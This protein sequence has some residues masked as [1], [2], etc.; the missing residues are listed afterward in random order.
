MTFDPLLKPI[1]T[2]TQQKVAHWY[3][4]DKTYY[5]RSIFDLV[6]FID[7]NGNEPEYFVP[8]VHL[9]FQLHYPQ[10]E[11]LENFEQD[12]EQV[13]SEIKLKYQDFSKNYL[14]ELNSNQ[15]FF[16]LEKF[17]GNVQMDSN[18]DKKRKEIINEVNNFIQYPL[19]LFIHH[20]RAC[21]DLQERGIGACVF[22]DVRG[23][24]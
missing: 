18:D 17:G 3:Q 16:L 12:K 19:R 22:G 8:P 7:R 23:M 2:E 11:H 10:A 13:L 1:F 21:C 9:S 5:L 6:G 14:E 24:M 4:N 20:D 15:L